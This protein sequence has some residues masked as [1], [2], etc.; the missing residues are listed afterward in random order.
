MQSNNFR[1]SLRGLFVNYLWS[2]KKEPLKHERLDMARVTTA[3]S[4][5]EIKN[6]KAREKNY[7]LFDGRGLF[8]LVNKT[9][10]K[11]WKLKYIFEG[12]EKL[13]ALGAYPNLSLA[14]ARMQRDLYKEQVLRG[15]DPSAERK[16][17]KEIF[18]ED[19]QKKINTVENIA[20]AYFEKRNELNYA[21]KVRLERSFKNDVFPFIGKLSIKDVTAKDIIGIVKHVESR[22]AIE[23]SHRLF[24][25]I[26][27]LFKYA[28]S[29]Q[30]ADRNPCNDMDK[31]EILK[32]H[33][34]KHYPTITNP[35][36]IKDLLNAIAE[37]SGDY[38]TKMALK[39]APHV[40]VRPHNLR[41]A[42]WSEIDFENKLWK[43]KAEK[44]KTKREH[45]IPLT[46]ATLEIFK[47]MHKYSSDAKYI[48]HSLRSKTQAMSDATLNN[49]LRR[50][51]Y[52]KDELVVHGF[53]AMFS[54]IA[55]EKSSFSHE[56]IETQLAHSVGSEVSR[57]YNRALY[58]HEREDLMHWWSDYLLS[59]EKAEN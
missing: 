30:L 59:L 41:F 17:K 9:G 49:A 38:T 16:A 22:G 23:S 53:R 13:L 7:K 33:V 47:E 19:I 29:N 24:T 1:G 10:S 31:N 43:I 28:V 54:T 11:L 12:K 4:A 42:E 14:D 45:I 2:T 39:L 32:A 3:L 51:G 37:Y 40:F 44:M 36:E 6:A 48:F 8:L 26:S 56:V 25:Q 21:Y 5:T 55:H 52:S 57:A 18:K 34:K 15:I 27:K 20:D 58:L 46:D 35:K 50:L